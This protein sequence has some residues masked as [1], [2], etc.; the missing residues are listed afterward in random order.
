MIKIQEDICKK[1][2]GVTSLFLEFEYNQA[3]IDTLQD[4]KYRV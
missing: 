3:I 1:L 2:P 4:Y